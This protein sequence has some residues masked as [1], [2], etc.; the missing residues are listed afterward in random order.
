MFIYLPAYGTPAEA[1]PPMSTLSVYYSYTTMNI[2]NNTIL[3]NSNTVSNM[4][5][6]KLR[7]KQI[8]VYFY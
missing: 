1:E 6:D 4:G 7:V 2:I 3:G 5:Y 8:H